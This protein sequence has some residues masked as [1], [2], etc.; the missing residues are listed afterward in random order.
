[1][2][3]M[4]HIGETNNDDADDND[5]DEDNDDLNTQ[6]SCRAHCWWPDHLHHLCRRTQGEHALPSQQWI[7]ALSLFNLNNMHFQ[8]E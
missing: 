8:L 2:I 1:M 6:G 3:L 5:D 7:P 4:R